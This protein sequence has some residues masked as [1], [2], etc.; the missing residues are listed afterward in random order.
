MRR[1]EESFHAS[2][3]RLKQSSVY[4]LLVH[5][6][7]D[8][9]KPGGDRLYDAMASFKQRGLVAKIGF[10][11][12]T[13]EQVEC[14]TALFHFDM[15]QAPVNVLDQRLLMGGHLARL[16]TQGIE[17]HA[18]SVFLQGLLLMEPEATPPYFAP[19][20][21]RLQDWRAVATQHGLTPLEAALGFVLGLKD[22]DVVLCGVNNVAQLEEV[23]H[24]ARARIAPEW[25]SDLPIRETAFLHPSVAELTR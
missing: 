16:K 13:P 3:D 14:A 21:H 6:V 22:V 2:L 18:R 8:L 4:G 10:S 5:R 19:I 15:I 20:R 12:Y 25:F 1:L 24:A 11:A 17:I 9:L 7:D 23:I